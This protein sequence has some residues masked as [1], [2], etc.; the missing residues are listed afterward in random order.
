MKKS[1]ILNYLV[2]SIVYIVCVILYVTH[3][4][5]TEYYDFKEHIYL[6]CLATYIYGTLA[7]MKKQKFKLKEY[8]RWFLLFCFTSS[9]AYLILFIF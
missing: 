2:M 3:D 7:C 6:I 9:L 5:N 4:R 1:K 8:K